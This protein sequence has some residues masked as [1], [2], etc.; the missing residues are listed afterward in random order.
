ME[1][2]PREPRRRLFGNYENSPDYCQPNETH[3][4]QEFGKSDLEDGQIYLQSE[5]NRSH[6]ETNC[7]AKQRSFKSTHAV[8]RVSVSFADL[9]CNNADGIYRARTDQI[10]RR[11]DQIHNDVKV[12]ITSQHQVK[13]TLVVLE[14][15]DEAGDQAHFVLSDRRSRPTRS[16][17]S[18]TQLPSW[19][20]S[21]TGQPAL[22]RRR[23]TNDGPSSQFQSGEIRRDQVGA[24]ARSLCNDWADERV[25]ALSSKRWLG[26]IHG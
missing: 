20:D 21:S 13:E 2:R 11:L 17:T 12:L 25:E 14:N 26:V 18:E 16:T 4:D 19:M 3:G 23:T 5:E 15:E 24:L 22:T 1:A 10:S 8:S 6:Q 7:D 9:V